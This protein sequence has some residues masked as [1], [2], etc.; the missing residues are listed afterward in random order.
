M[1]I[2]SDEILDFGPGAGEHGGQ[3]IAQGN[4]KQIMA[5][6]QSLTGKYLSGKKRVEV[7]SSQ[8]SV[9]GNYVKPEQ[10]TDN[11]LTIVGAREHNLKNI[12]VEFPLGKFICITGV[13]GSGKSTLIHDILYNALAE[14]FYRSRT[15]PGDFDYL[16]GFE[17]LDKVIL[18]DKS[19]I[20]RTPRSNPATY[21]GAFTPIRGLFAMTR[22]ARVKGYP[23]G[24]FSFNVKGGRCEACE[25]EGQIKIEM[26]FLPD[27]YVECEV[28]RGKRYNEIALEIL[29]HDK[30][31][32]DILDMTVEDAMGFFANI[33][34]LKSK[35]DTQTDVGLGYIKLGQ[36][37]PTLSGGE[38]Q[39]VK[40][41]TELSKKATGKTIYILDDPT[42]GLHFADI[43]RLLLILKRL[44]STGNT[45][46]II[47]HNMDVIKNSDWIIDLGP[48]GGDEGGRLVAEGTPLQVSKVKTSYTGQFLA[49][50]L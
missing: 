15:K 26:N 45:V 7:L 21:T 33:P 20:G 5:N 2:S 29:Y 32:A 30:N 38:A 11:K 3:I 23:A 50:N 1:M 24:R 42:T 28:C 37:A 19:P 16:S 9:L 18:I 36:P 4:P 47:E 12:T 25:G 46:I 34:P 10:L 31:I 35:L 41:A 13:S 48:E 44:V 17:H 49:K 39:R 22:E 6:T 27:V 8:F 14:R 43:E 40:L